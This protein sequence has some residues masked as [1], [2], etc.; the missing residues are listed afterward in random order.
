MMPRIF[1]NLGPGSSLLRRLQDTL[2]HSPRLD[3]CVGY[4][5][6]RGWGGLAVYV[7]DWNQ[8]GSPCRVLIEMQQLPHDELRAALPKPRFRCC[9]VSV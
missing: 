3:F 8:G 2:A 9:H 1:D 4:F 7:D 5:N 6:L